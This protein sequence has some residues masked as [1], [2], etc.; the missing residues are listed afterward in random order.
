MAERLMPSIHTPRT[1]FRIARKAGTQAKERELGFM[2]ELSDELPPHEQRHVRA[3]R[4]MARVDVI[5]TR[6]VRELQRSYPW[7]SETHVRKEVFH[8]KRERTGT[9]DE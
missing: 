4:G 7:A 9:L 1:T 8:L 2:D 3:G 6:E 5:S